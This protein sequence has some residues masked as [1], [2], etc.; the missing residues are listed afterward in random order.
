MSGVISIFLS[1]LDIP[2]LAELYQQ[3]RQNCCYI[4]RTFPRITEI[5]IRFCNH[6]LVNAHQAVLCDNIS[7]KKNSVYLTLIKCG[8]IPH[9]ASF[10]RLESRKVD[11]G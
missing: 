6:F 3:P 9:S 7:H 11:R 1:V 2:V 4:S 10:F 8:H 5:L